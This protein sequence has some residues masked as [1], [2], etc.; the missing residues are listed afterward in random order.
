MSYHSYLFMCIYGSILIY[1]N[2]GRGGGEQGREKYLQAVHGSWKFSTASMPEWQ[3]MINFT[4]QFRSTFDVSAI[5]GIN[6]I[7]KQVTGIQTADL[8]PVILN[9]QG[10]RSLSWAICCAEPEESAVVYSYLRCINM[11]FGVIKGRSHR[12]QSIFVSCLLLF[13]P[14]PPRFEKPNKATRQH[15]PDRW[16]RKAGM[17]FAVSPE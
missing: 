1:G 13:P 3:Q 8:Y 15:H 2:L 14:S 4:L 12:N 6:V 9:L 17:A 10:A 16:L 11:W 7:C 5:T